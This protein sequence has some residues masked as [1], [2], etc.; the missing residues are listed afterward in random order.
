M[1]EN[2]RERYPVSEGLEVLDGFDLYRSS[3][4]I[5]ALVVV[6][7]ERGKDLR[8]YRWQKRRKRDTGEE[9]WKVD[10]AR[11]SVLRWD[12]DE[13]AQKVKDLKQKHGLA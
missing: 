1:S 12:W 13:I 3:N 4:L 11:F 7:S 8:F 9:N 5:M 6:R 10:L 2:L